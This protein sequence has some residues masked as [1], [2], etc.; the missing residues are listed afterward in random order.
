MKS[1]KEVNQ[2][3]KCIEIIN[4]NSDKIEMVQNIEGVDSAIKHAHDIIEA[5]FIIIGKKVPSMSIRQM[6]IEKYY[7]K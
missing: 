5:Y 7:N 4:V 6:A 2:F 1:T 3:N